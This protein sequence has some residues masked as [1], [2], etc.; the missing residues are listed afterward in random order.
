M[1]CFA[2]HFFIINVYTDVSKNSLV[3]DAPNQLINFP[4]TFIVTDQ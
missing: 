1:S 3:I 2:G 4:F